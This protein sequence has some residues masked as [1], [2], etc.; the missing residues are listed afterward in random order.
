MKRERERA[1]VVPWRAIYGTFHFFSSLFIPAP[2]LPTILPLPPPRRH[3]GCTRVRTLPLSSSPSLVPVHSFVESPLAF[4][5]HET[6]NGRWWWWMATQVEVANDSLLSTLFIHSSTSPSLPSSPPHS[7][8]EATK[9]EERRGIAASA[10]SRL[11][12]SQFNHFT[13]G[14]GT[15]EEE[16]EGG[17][18]VR[19][20]RFIWRGRCRPL[21]YRHT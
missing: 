19:E 10:K 11:M 4:S 2:S 21:L 14:R 13:I 9:G 12:K 8:F 18:L 15:I 6:R 17:R 3:T 20:G 5:A 16:K 1:V 7:A